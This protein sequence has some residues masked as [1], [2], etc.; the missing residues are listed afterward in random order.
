MPSCTNRY[1]IGNSNYVAARAN[2]SYTIPMP[3]AHFYVPEAPMAHTVP[4]LGT[5][6]KAGSLAVISLL[7]DTGYA[8][9]IYPKGYEANISPNYWWE[10]PGE[11]HDHQY[12]LSVSA[13]GDMA[14][15]EVLPAPTPPPRFTMG[16]R[17]PDRPPSAGRIILPDNTDMLLLTTPAEGEAVRIDGAVMHFDEATI[18]AWAAGRPQRKER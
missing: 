13:E 8:F 12:Y 14:T 2:S 11:L 3:L 4:D 16:R 9:N 7:R 17:Q 18:E 1:F 5:I 15:V 6:T 10:D